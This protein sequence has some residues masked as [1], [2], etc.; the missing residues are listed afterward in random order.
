MALDLLNDWEKLKLTEDEE[1]VVGEKSG[2]IDD[3]DTDLK[4]SLILV[5]KL[6]TNK[7]FNVEAMQKTIQSIWKIREKIS[8]RTVD[9]NL[10]VFQFNNAND[11]ARVL[12]GCPWWF[13]NQLLLLQEVRS[14]QQPSEVSFNRSPFWVRLLDVP[15]GRRNEQMAKEIGE[16]LGGFIEFD[17]SDPLG[18]E[19]FMRIKVRIDLNKPLRRGLKIGQMGGSTKWIDVKYERLSD[20]CYFCGRLGHVDR[21][22]SFH[23]RYEDS[24]EELVYQYGPWLHAS[25]HRRH[26]P[27]SQTCERERQWLEGFRKGKT[28]TIRGYSDPNAIKLGPPSTVRRALFKNPGSL[29]T[30]DETGRI[31]AQEFLN[32]DAIQGIKE[33]QGEIPQKTYAEPEGMKPLEESTEP[34]AL[35]EVEVAEHVVNMGEKLVLPH[36]KLG[37]GGNDAETQICTSRRVRKWKRVIDPRMITDEDDMALGPGNKRKEGAEITRNI[38]EKKLRY[39]STESEGAGLPKALGDQ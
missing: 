13:D 29:A 30:V 18:W 10:F 17:N 7:S 25:P 24:T 12:E 3:E 39:D 14:D 32:V 22:C 5:G 35:T 31:D 8:V 23:E 27:P 36:L 11:K 38:C 4:I 28:G 37:E 6:Y 26:K 2:E 16:A 1:I 34:E 19:E 20:F 9:T 15:F 21:D 33:R